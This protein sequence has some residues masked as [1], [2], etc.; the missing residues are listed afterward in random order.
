VIDGY[1]S[2]YMG[3]GF[4]IILF[5]IIILARYRANEGTSRVVRTTF[6]IALPIVSIIILVIIYTSGDYYYSALAFTV[7]LTLIFMV[8]TLFYLLLRLFS[9]EEFNRTSFFFDCITIIG[10]CGLIVNAIMNHSISADT[11]VVILL[12]T[13][14]SI[15]CGQFFR[16]KTKRYIG[17]ILRF[18]I[19]LLVL[20]IFVYRFESVF[21]AV[22]IFLVLGFLVYYAYH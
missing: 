15:L 11:G 3:I 14:I 2:Y 20:L 10:A 18:G 21:Y 9:R 7:M 19:P 1:M 5:S 6:R 8:L 4:I 22:I 16:G 13:M 17:Y 12:I